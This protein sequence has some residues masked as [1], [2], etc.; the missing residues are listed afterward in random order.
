MQKYIHI[1]DTEYRE[2]CR[3]GLIIGRRQQV[4]QIAQFLQFNVIQCS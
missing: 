3:L 2:Q 1:D 4:S